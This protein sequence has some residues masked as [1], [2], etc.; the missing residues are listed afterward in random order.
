MRRLSRREFLRLAGGTA[1]AAPFL[2]LPPVVAARAETQG[3]LLTTLARTLERGARDGEGTQKDYF[4]LRSGPG[5]PHILRT[6]LA[7]PQPPGQRRT[8]LHFVHYTDMQLADPQS[9]ARVEFLDRFS[10]Q[11]CEPIPFES[12]WR[13]QEAIHFQAF[14]RT[15]RTVRAIGSSPVTGAPLQFAMCTG[16][17]IDN[18][19]WNELRQFIGIM[20]GG[21]IE[22]NSGGPQFEGVQ[23]ATWGTPSLEVDTE[24]WH[25]DDVSDK[26]K[27][28]YGFPAY[29]GLL[30]RS[31]EPF[32]ARGAGLP[33][34]SCFGNHDG[35]MQGNAHQ[36][37]VFE[38]FAVGSV[39][40]T[41]PPPG[42]NPCDQFENFVSH[43]EALFA[44]PGRAVTADPDRK[45]ITRREYVEEHFH[46]TSKPVGHGF[47]EQNRQD[48]TAYYVNDRS[49]RIRQIVLDTTNPGGLS[50]GSIGATQLAWLEQ[51]LIEAHSR[52]YDAGGSVVETGNQDRLV[53]LFSHHGLDTLNNPVNAPDPFTPEQNDLPRHTAST[54]RPLVHR[55]PNVI[56]WVIGHTHQNQVLA[57]PDPEGKTN[58]FWDV[59]TSAI[60]DWPC[61]TRLIELV[62]NGNGTLSIFGTMVDHGAPPDPTRA[63]TRLD[64]LAS[65]H[66][67]LASN[68]PQAGI[69]G[70]HHGTPADRNVELL[71]PAPFPLS[72]AGGRRSSR[73]IPAPA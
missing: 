28:E 16:D 23:A 65:V 24:Y 54:V 44:G 57:R 3:W 38:S 14:E 59:T 15:I 60:C 46:T 45:I 41:G 6:E 36:N 69:D 12:A 58:G 62:D 47:S 19:Q 42:L 53:V 29:P 66:R 7:Q 56:L 5:E 40:V 68:D 22:S 55:F 73:R 26:Y 50:D 61:Q 13:P 67:E 71:I 31:I 10:D 52:Y 63:R 43:P 25:P 33:W 32:R 64:L 70:G 9:P 51:R 8:L 72:R 17:N 20:D 34:F 27:L 49:P 4:R 48:G 21:V 1:M 39:K 30:E 37:P 18:E 35:L 11:D 2:G